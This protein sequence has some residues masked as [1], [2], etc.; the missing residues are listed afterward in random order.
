MA[1]NIQIEHQSDSGNRSITLTDKQLRIFGPL[2][3][4]TLIFGFFT[5]QSLPM[6]STVWV[7]HAVALAAL[8][9]PLGYY[10]AKAMVMLIPGLKAG[11]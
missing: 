4:F 8:G 6:G 7:S 3:C 5:L 10:F 9:S 1:A 2:V 11:R